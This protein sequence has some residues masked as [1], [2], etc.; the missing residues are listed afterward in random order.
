V[1]GGV[2][3]AG[4][5]R[6]WLCTGIMGFAGG[7]RHAGSSVGGTSACCCGLVQGYPVALKL[8]STQYLGA[9]VVQDLHLDLIWVFNASL[10]TIRRDVLLST[11]LPVWGMVAAGESEIVAWCRRAALNYGLLWRAAYCRATRA[12]WHVESDQ[13]SVAQCL[14]LS[15]KSERLWQYLLW[16]CCSQLHHHEQTLAPPAPPACVAA[17]TRLMRAAVDPVTAGWQFLQD[18]VL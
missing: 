12:A 3:V 15:T 14:H 5:S 4:E 10:S 6:L 8:C 18:G 11:S 16:F 13:R 7:A 9:G 1:W 17:G 2:L